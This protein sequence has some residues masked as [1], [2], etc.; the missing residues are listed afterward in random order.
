MAG[1]YC[2]HVS[3]RSS[4]RSMR[5][6][7]GLFFPV[8]FISLFAWTVYKLWRLYR[9]GQFVAVLPDGLLLKD[10]DPSGEF[11]CWHNIGRADVQASPV[12][13]VVFIKDIKMVRTIVG[14]FLRIE[15]AEAFVVEVTR[16][17]NL[18]PAG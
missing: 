17:I 5:E 4:P 16:R 14:P 13:A 3:L 7:F 10:K 11:V 2:F 15:D 18:I 9:Q 12:G 8:L 6:L 1:Y